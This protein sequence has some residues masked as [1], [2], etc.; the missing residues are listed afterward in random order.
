MLFYWNYN[1][2]PLYGSIKRDKDCWRGKLEGLVNGDL[3]TYEAES[4]S[5][6]YQ[7]FKDAIIDYWDICERHDK[8]LSFSHTKLPDE[9]ASEAMG[10]TLVLEIYPVFQPEKKMF[11]KETAYMIKTT[12]DEASLLFGT[13]P[14]YETAINHAKLAMHDILNAVYE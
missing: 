8:I 13:A 5:D 14:T 3:V 6:L 10:Q 7:Q 2:V 12:G 9:I 4:Q 1:G 11:L